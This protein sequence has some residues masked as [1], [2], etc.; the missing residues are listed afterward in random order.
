M[1]MPFADNSFDGI[2]AIEATCHAPNVVRTFRTFNGVFV[3]S[4][5]LRST[6]ILES[7]IDHYSLYV[8]DD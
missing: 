2:F 4:G 5:S 6:W 8:V 1:C 7:I 3:K